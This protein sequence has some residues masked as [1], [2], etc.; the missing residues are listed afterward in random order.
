[1]KLNYFSNIEIEYFENKY[2]K[3]KIKN[4]MN[5]ELKKKLCLTISN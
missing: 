1:M 4:T 3:E 5:D 2:L